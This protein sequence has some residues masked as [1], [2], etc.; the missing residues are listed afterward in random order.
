MDYLSVKQTAKRLGVSTKT[1]YRMVHRDELK[2]RP[3]GRLIRIP[4]SELGPT[5][6]V[7]SP[8]RT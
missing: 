7:L 2:Y 6:P 8:D 3:V 5:V 4:E 1:V